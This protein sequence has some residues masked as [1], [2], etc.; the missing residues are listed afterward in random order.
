MQSYLSPAQHADLYD[1]EN[2]WTAAEDFFLAFANEQPASRVL[3]LGCGTGRL[4]IALAGAGHTV[5]G[6]DPAPGFARRGP[7]Q[8]RRRRGA[9][10]RRDLRGAA[11][12][13]VRST[14]SS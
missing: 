2:A 9:L 14:P 6:V 8:A 4:T 10:D 1:A 7:G 5:T 13:C 12:G 11:G 3:D